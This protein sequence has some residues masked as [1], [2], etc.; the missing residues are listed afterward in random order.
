MIE[1]ALAAGKSALDEWES[2]MLFAAYG[3]AVPQGALAKDEAEAVAA[4]A[5][6]GGRVVMKGVASEIH[7][8]TEAGLVVLGLD[9]GDA[10][11]IGRTFRLLQERAKGALEAVLIEQMIASTRELMVGVKRDAAF[12]PVVAFGLGGVLT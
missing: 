3:I 12:G 9:A 10:D 8:K 2:K 6:I 5:R 4:A 11:E 1:A 7:H